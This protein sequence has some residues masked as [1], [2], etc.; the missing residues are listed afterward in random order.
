MLKE[1]AQAEKTL[2]IRTSAH[3]VSASELVVKPTMCLV[4][5][6]VRFQ[7]CEKDIESQAEFQ[8]TYRTLTYL[9]MLD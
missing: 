5:G 2:N 3:M 9:E 1:L 6:C 7:Y 4:P 8:R